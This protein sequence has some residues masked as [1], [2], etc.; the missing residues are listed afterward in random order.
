M[1]RL[2]DLPISMICTEIKYHTHVHYH[3]QA[4]III[5]IIDFAFNL[6]TNTEIGRKFLY[7]EQFSKSAQKLCDTH[8]N[9][10]RAFENG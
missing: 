1:V 4:M 10:R 3:L 9:I 6:R 7:L 8:T 2:T 5:Q